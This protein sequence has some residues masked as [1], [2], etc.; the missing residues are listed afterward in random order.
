MIPEV[1]I[2]RQPCAQLD[3][4]VIL[5]RALGLGATDAVECPVNSEIS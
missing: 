1:F 2:L 4:G 5:L 3:S